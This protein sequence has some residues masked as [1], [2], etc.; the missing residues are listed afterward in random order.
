MIVSSNYTDLIHNPVYN[1]QSEPACSQS[2]QAILINFSSLLNREEDHWY[3]QIPVE[4]CLGVNKLSIA[5][6]NKRD[7]G[8]RREPL[9]EITTQLLFLSQKAAL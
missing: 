5:G 9:N 6:L 2:Q 4:R 7:N 1:P 8:S 3:H